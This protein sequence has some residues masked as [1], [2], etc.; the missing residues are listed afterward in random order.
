M[1]AG[2]FHLYFVV[3]FFFYKLM[4]LKMSLWHLFD[5]WVTGPLGLP[6]TDWGGRTGWWHCLV[7]GALPGQPPCPGLLSSWVLPMTCPWSGC[8]Y[9][10]GMGA[11]LQTVLFCPRRSARWKSILFCASLSKFLRPLHRPDV[12]LFSDESPSFAQVEMNELYHKWNPSLKSH[13]Q[14][15]PASTVLALLLLMT[16]QFL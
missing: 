1:F 7:A 11:C 3:L 9:L 15:K 16:K 13:Y 2:Q 8:D 14:I 10:T 12:C 6:L 5:A 4:I